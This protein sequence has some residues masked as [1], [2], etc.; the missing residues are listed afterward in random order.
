MGPQTQIRPAVTAQ[1]PLKADRQDIASFIDLLFRYAT[2][3]SYLSLRVFDQVSRNVPPVLIEAVRLSSG[4]SALIGRACRAASIAA[5]A[6]RPAVF[7]PPVATFC[8]PKTA[9]MVDLANGVALSVEID[10]ANPARALKVLSHLVGPPTAVVHSGGEWTDPQT[11]EV[12]RRQHLHW[13]LSEPTAARQDHQRLQEA[14]WLAALMVGA[15]RS[16]APPA[17]PLRWPGSWNIKSTPRLATIVAANPRSEIHLEDTLEQLQ[18]AVEAAGLR[19]RDWKTD[20]PTGAVHA[21]HAEIVDALP[22]VPNPDLDWEQWNRVGMAVWAATRGSEG[23]LRAWCQWSGKSDKHDETACMDRWRHFATSPPSRIGAGTI[24]YLARQNGWMRGGRSSPAPHD[25]EGQRA[26]ELSADA[27]SGPSP[28][29]FPQSGD[30]PGGQAAPSPTQQKR[31]VHGR[32]PTS[33]RPKAAPR[34]GRT[35]DRDPTS[36]FTSGRTELTEDGV[37]IVFCQ[38]HTNSLRYCHDTGAWFVWSGTHWQQNRNRI[39]FAWARLLIRR[40]NRGSEPRIKAITGKVSFASGVETFAQA[41]RAFALNA[42]AW[43]QDPFLLGT[44]GGTVDLRTGM[45]RP[46]QQADMITKITAVAPSD[47]GDDCSA[48]LRFLHEAT[49]NDGSLVRFLQQWCGYC[50]TGS[51]RE[52]ALLFIYGPGGNGKSVFLKIV[53]R[54]LGDY[55]RTAPMEA[56]TA[57]TGDRHPTEI[58]MLRGARMVVATETEEGRAWAESRIKQLTGGDLISA[59]F[60]RQDFFTFVPAFKLTIAGNHKPAL[61]NVDG[62]ARRRFNIVPFLNEPA[63]PDRD[64]EEKLWLEAP[65][66]LRWMISGCLDWQRHGLL[67]PAVVTEATDE[68]FEAQDVIGRWITERCILDGSLSEKPGRLATDCQDWARAS[69]EVPPTGPQFRGTLEKVRGVSYRTVRG[70]RRVHGIG[71][72]V[73]DRVQE[74]ASWTG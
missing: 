9:R 45:I 68:Y 15:D 70:D 30:D 50:L 22:H 37:A 55:V 16:A 17:H 4:R 60:M 72:R 34:P 61:R 31:S 2:P 51:T 42:E 52:H 63:A 44:P 65:G 19:T 11:G 62:A 49:A 35:Y 1:A 13:R 28:F 47:R 40:L 57:S 20:R 73:Q 48:W 43:D 7:A 59:R 66:I 33:Q 23:G 53:S 10:A 71:L 8:N 12:H 41:D 69:G 58:A 32:D 39:A 25:K 3:D 26:S 56:F 38:T 27:S 54:V 74:G 21:S 67:R 24:F 14:R 46:A 18:D 5:N 29:H 36:A 64:L 6:P